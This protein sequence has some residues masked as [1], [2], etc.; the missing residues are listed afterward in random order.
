M[1]KANSG[2]VAVVGMQCIFPGAPDLATYWKNIRTGT[3]SFQDVPEHRWPAV[4]YDPDSDR[5]DRFYCQVGGFV[6]DYA[7]F[8]PLAYGIMPIAAAGSEPDQM[9]A[10]DVAAR[11]RRSRRG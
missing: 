1:A 5:V 6:D 4:Y 8:D 11:R 7:V 10:L 3:K 2:S 9:L